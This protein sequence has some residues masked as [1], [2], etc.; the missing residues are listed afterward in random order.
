LLGALERKFWV[1][2][3]RGVGRTDLIVA[4]NGTEIDMGWDNQA[5]R[6]EL[7]PIFA[8]AS[9]EEWD[10]RFVEWD[11]PGCTVLQ[12]PDVMA[13]PHFEA[14][15]LLE[16]APGSWPSMRSAVRWHHTGERAGS[17]LSPPPEIDEHRREILNE[18][19]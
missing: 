14:R 12:V 4:H 8:G 16:G 18:W 9:A 2:F 5:L 7:R 19:L 17:W 13:H 3:C 15:E 11:C 1:N 10:R 6:D